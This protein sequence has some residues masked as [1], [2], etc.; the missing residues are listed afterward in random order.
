MI[1]SGQADLWGA[2]LAALFTANMALIS[3]IYRGTVKEIS[4]IKKTLTN[5]S[6]A[7]LSLAITIAPDKAPKIIQDF[8][9]ELVGGKHGK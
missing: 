7:M 3:I 9:S 8:L 4:I 1:V 2:V 5:L 6:A